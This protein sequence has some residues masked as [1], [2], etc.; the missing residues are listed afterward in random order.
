MGSLKPIHGPQAE[1]LENLPGIENVV[2]GIKQG[3]EFG[4]LDIFFLLTR[5]GCGFF[6]HIAKA[7]CQEL[8]GTYRNIRNG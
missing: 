5:L 8:K 2:I 6:I 1:N 3:Q 7:V 4:C